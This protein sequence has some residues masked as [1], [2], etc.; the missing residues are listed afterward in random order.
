MAA[1]TEAALATPGVDSAGGEASLDLASDPGPDTTTPPIDPRADTASESVPAE[2]AAPP[3][4][5]P[6]DLI[7]TCDLQPIML[8]LADKRG[9]PAC[10][11]TT[12]STPEG[13]ID[14]NGEGRVLMITIADVGT[15][16]TQ[17]WADSLAGVRWPCMASQTLGYGCAL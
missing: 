2:A 6:G 14:F 10:Y 3:V 12:S 1:T 17:A 8:L 9:R 13:Y 4:D 15:P 5:V 16:E 11:P 7:F